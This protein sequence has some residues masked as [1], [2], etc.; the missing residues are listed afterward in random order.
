MVLGRL[1]ISCMI[2]NL[3]ASQHD[4]P[5]TSPSRLRLIHQVPI[6]AHLIQASQILAR[7]DVDRSAAP[8]RFR[9]GS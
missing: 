2:W 8:S 7:S 5:L 9:P 3:P 4:L 6:H 1:S